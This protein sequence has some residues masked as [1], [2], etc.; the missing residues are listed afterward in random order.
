MEGVTDVNYRKAGNIA[1]R[2]RTAGGKIF[3]TYM[4][5]CRLARVSVYSLTGRWRTRSRFLSWGRP[6]ALAETTM[7]RS[8][9]FH[10]LR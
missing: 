7:T 1:G 5:G 2:G 3:A 4:D 10:S 6:R 8:L 9:S